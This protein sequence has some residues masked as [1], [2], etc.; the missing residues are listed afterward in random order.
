MPYGVYPVPQQQRSI[1]RPNGPSLAA[2]ILIRLRGRA[3]LDRQLA[4]GA[5]PAFSPELTLRAE[6]LHAPTERARIANALVKAVGDARRGEPVTI[7]VRRQREAVRDTADDIL[8]LALRLRDGRPM[9][10]S[11]VAMAAW[12]AGSKSSPMYRE[13]AGDLREAIRLAHAGVDSSQPHTADELTAR[14]A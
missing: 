2:R 7:R 8:A 11:A 1:A 3:N 9:P 13:G 4:H 14:A 6:Q 10:T 5:D 12:L